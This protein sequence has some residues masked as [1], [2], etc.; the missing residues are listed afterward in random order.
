VLP[1]SRSFEKNSEKPLFFARKA[2][3]KWSCFVAD[4]S[5]TIQIAARPPAA[6][7]PQLRKKLLKD[8][9][10]LFK[11]YGKQPCGRNKIRES[12]LETT[13]WLAH[14]GDASVF[15]VFREFA[16]NDRPITSRLPADSNRP[17]GPSYKITQVVQRLRISTAVKA[18]FR[19]ITSR[20]PAVGRKSARNR[21]WHSKH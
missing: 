19:P 7:F 6:T 9:C 1:L 12:I 15:N 11:R 18:D 10:F 13:T 17:R 21:L 16:E 5:R 14:K 2:A 20:L 4:T 8:H 3:G